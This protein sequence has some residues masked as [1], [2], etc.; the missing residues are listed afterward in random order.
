MQRQKTKGRSKSL[1][2]ATDIAVLRVMQEQAHL[3]LPLTGVLSISDF[4]DIGFL[5]QAGRLHE[6]N[7]GSVFQRLRRTRSGQ[8]SKLRT[9]SVGI[10]CSHNRRSV[11]KF[12]AYSSLHSRYFGRLSRPWRTSNKILNEHMVRVGAFMALWVIGYGIVQASAPRLLHRQHHG[13]GTVATRHG[14]GPLSWPSSRPAWRS[15]CTMSGTR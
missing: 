9:L 15:G 7:V 12:A 5:G 3:K 14:C 11:L 6:A 2:I 8:F 4:I 10:I 1:G 13:R